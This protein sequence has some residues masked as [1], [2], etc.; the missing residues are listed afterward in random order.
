MAKRVQPDEDRYDRFQSCTLCG[1]WLCS[2][3]G[4]QI[5]GDMLCRDCALECIEEAE[6]IADSPFA[7]RSGTRLRR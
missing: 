5:A 7:D 6:R 4:V 2:A 1:I 3:E